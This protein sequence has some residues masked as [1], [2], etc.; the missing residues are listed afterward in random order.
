MNPL[1]Q[2]A[3]RD[4]Y[5]EEKDVEQLNDK[6]KKKSSDKEIERRSDRKEGETDEEQRLRPQL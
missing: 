4:E 5:T 2:E 1:S 3:E 6:R